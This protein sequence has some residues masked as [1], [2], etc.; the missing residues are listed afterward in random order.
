MSRPLLKGPAVGAAAF[1]LPTGSRTGAGAGAEEQ[2]EQEEQE[3]P[4]A[5]PLAVTSTTTH[6]HHHRCQRHHCRQRQQPTTSSSAFL[7]RCPQCGTWLLSSRSK[8]THPA[9]MFCRAPSEVEHH[10]SRSCCQGSADKLVG[11]YT[12]LL[13]CPL[14]QA[15]SVTISS[16]LKIV[17]ILGLHMLARIRAIWSDL[18]VA[19]GLVHVPVSEEEVGNT[20]EAVPASPCIRPP[21]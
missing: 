3:E 10:T 7:L 19:G 9:S 12:G 16:K 18:L 6:R 1:S 15:Q 5:P 11:S 8:K 17:Q 21:S 13:P 14:R 2:E 20:G 4:A